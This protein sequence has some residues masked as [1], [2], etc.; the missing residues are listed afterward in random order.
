MMVKKRA[1]LAL[2]VA[3]SLCRG[4]SLADRPRLDVRA[5]AD[6]A[7]VVAESAIESEVYAAEEFQ[8]FFH[9]ASGLKLPIVHKITRWDKHVFIGPGKVMHTSPICEIQ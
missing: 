3:V 2:V 8:E 7:I 6:W 1:V 4:N 5:M 9:Q